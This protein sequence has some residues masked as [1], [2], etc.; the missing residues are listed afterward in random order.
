ML[1]AMTAYLLWILLI[2]GLAL[3]LLRLDRPRPVQVPV[4]SDR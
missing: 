1:F 3:H 2:L 4:R